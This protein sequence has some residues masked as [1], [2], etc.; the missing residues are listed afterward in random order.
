MQ[1][2]ATQK[3]LFRFFSI[4]FFLFAMS[5]QFLVSFAFD[6]VWRKVVPWFSATF[7]N[8]IITTFTNGSGD[9]LYNWTS[10]LVYI[11]V[12]IFG[13]V[14]WTAFDQKRR[15]YSQLF[16]WLV[17]IIRYYV[18]YQMLIYGFAKLFYMQ[19]QPPRLT[20]LIQPYGDS[21]PMGILW[22][23]M[24]QSKGYTI[25]AGVGELVG[26]LFLLFRR[27][28]LLGACIVFGVMANVM[29]MNFFYDV[30]VKILSSHLVLMSLFLI[31]LDYRRIINFFFTNGSYVEPKIYPPHF[32]N[33]KLEK[34]KNI[35]KWILVLIGLGLMTF[36]M[37]NMSKQYGPNA[38]RS[39]FYGLYE[40]ETFVKNNDT[41]PP[42]ATDEPQM[43]EG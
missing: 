26:G 31:A 20:R 41:I 35:I 14:I 29:A 33:P 39:K 23:F 32:K 5:N 1:W 4:Y 24:G 6:A 25:F 30:P 36:Q 18:L 13:T 19:F 38:N 27:T 2:S 28:T 10:L 43:E 21:S 22:T 17:V 34:A 15:G 16:N 12:A 7:L 40:V 37:I 3:I 9:T 42:L 11:I 8:K